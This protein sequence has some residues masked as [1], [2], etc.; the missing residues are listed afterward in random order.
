MPKFTIT[1]ADKVTKHEVEGRAC[2]KHFFVH[3][4]VDKHIKPVKGIWNCTH[5]VSGASIGSLNTRAQAIMYGKAMAN[6][7][8]VDWTKM[9]PME[10]LSKEQK[11]ELGHYRNEA[12]LNAKANA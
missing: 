8:H 5:R 9:D 10:G 11:K 3:Q 12:K 1:A 7:P 6:A 2:G 4:A